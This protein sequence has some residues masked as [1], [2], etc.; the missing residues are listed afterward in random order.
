MAAKKVLLIEDDDIISQVYQHYFEKAGLSVYSV[1]TGPD[2]VSFAQNQEFDIIVLDI[3]IPGYDGFH[4]IEKLRENEKT[5][6]IPVM[7]LTNLDEDKYV[8][9]ATKLGASEYLIKAN[10]TPQ[11]ALEH[12]KS[13]TG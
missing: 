3:I 4:V 9:R 10:T 2:A 11:Q 12:I 8:K 7:I 13:L 5:A 1:Q 6:K